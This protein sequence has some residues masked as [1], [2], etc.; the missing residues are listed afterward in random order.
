[1]ARYFYTFSEQGIG[2]T[3]AGWSPI[4]DTSNVSWTNQTDGTN[5]FLRNANSSTNDK[6]LANTEV[7]QV[8]D[9]EVTMK[10]RTSQFGNYEN[11]LFVR[12]SPTNGTKQGYYLALNVPANQ[13]K[14]LNHEQ[15][16]NNGYLPWYA[17]DVGWT[18]NTWYWV[19]Y[20]VVGNNHK[21]KFWQ[22]GTAEPAGWTSDRTDSTGTQYN[23]AGYVALAVY[24]PNGSRDWD[25]VGIA[26]GG[27][28]APTNPIHYAASSFSGDSDIS[29]SATSVTPPKYFGA[30]SMSGDSDMTV[31]G[32]TSIYLDKIT[33]TVYNSTF[34]VG[35]DFTKSAAFSR[36]GQTFTAVAGQTALS[37]IK[38][39]LMSTTSTLGV[40]TVRMYNTPAEAN[41]DATPLGSS[42]TVSPT[43]DSVKDYTL[44]FPN[45][46]TLTPGNSYFFTVR[47][48]GTSVYVGYQTTDVYAGGTR[49][50]VSYGGAGGSNLLAADTGDLAFTAM[51][52]VA[53]SLGAASMSGD[54]DATANGYRVHFATSSFSGDS[55]TTVSVQRQA[56]GSSSF[57]GDSD[58][59]ATG[60]AGYFAVVNQDGDSTMTVNGA[61]AHYGEVIIDGDSEIPDVASSRNAV[62]S[63]SMSGDSEFTLNSGGIDVT[64]LA[65]TKSYI[66]KIYDENW[67][68][69]GIW[70][71]VISDFGY[72]QEINSAG[73]A[74]TVTL[75]RNSDSLIAQ[76]DAIA[77][78]DDEAILT[79]G[80]DE[81]AAEMTTLNAVGPGT[82][83]DLNKNVKIYEF[84]TDPDQPVDGDLVF[85]GYISKY[86]SKYGTAENTDV[87]IFSYGADLDNWV[88]TD[89]TNTRVSY[90]S[91]DPA[92]ILKDT[93]DRF[94]AE[95]GLI[96][97]DVGVPGDTEVTT[98]L[99]TNPS[100]ETNANGW[101][102]THGVGGRQSGSGGMFGTYYF[103]IQNM[104]GGNVSHSTGN[105]EAGNVYRLS[106]YLRRAASGTVNIWGA[107]N[108]TSVFDYYVNPPGTWTRYDIQFTATANSPLFLNIG[109]S[110]SDNVVYIDGVMLTKGPDLLDYFDGTTVSADPDISYGWTGTAHNSTSTKTKVINNEGAT[111]ENTQWYHPGW[112]TTYAFNVNTELEVVKK[113]LELSP[114][115]WFF[116]VD[117]ATN[118]L[119][120]HPRPEK[121]KHYFYLGKH[122]FSLDLEKNME[123]I[124]NDVI[125]TGGKPV[126]I[127]KD[128]FFDV[129]G[130]LLQNHEGELDATWVKHPNSGTGS[131]VITNNRVRS[132]TGEVVYLVSGATTSNDYV[133]T[134]DMRVLSNVGNIGLVGRADPTTNTYYMAR[135]NVSGNAELYKRVAGT[136]TLLKS[137][138]FTVNPG[139]TYKV[140]LKM[141]GIQISLRVDDDTIVDVEDSSI[142]FGSRSGLYS[143]T[144]GTATT[145]YHFNNFTVK[146]FGDSG[147]P[148]FK[149]KTNNDS[150][151]AYRRGLSRIQDNRVTVDQSAE[152]LM[153]NELNRNSEPRYRS[154]ITIS[155]STY[156][157]RSIRLGDLIGFRNFDNFVDA[158]VMQVVRI[159]YNGDSVTLQLDTLLPSV[160]KRLE[161]I[162]RNLAQ[163]DVED[164]PDAPEI[165]T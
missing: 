148:V 97:Y 125:L 61:K 22:D 54:S 159:D 38:L 154:K 14:I 80:G 86:T 57:S 9:V 151:V 116:Y 10:F 5:T 81:L 27:D 122:I 164:N 157:I 115:D 139:N 8:A 132:D 26:T 82:T 145:G 62:S 73:S 79:D 112:I 85:T 95:G 39:R 102:L 56:F 28:T 111:I 114:T 34:A 162:K 51:S 64:H 98:N 45:T 70:K 123:G 143:G 135:I 18:V 121:P 155:G 90:I 15:W 120:F 153:D 149:R 49:W 156:D 130:E 113:L 84:S 163:S 119:H 160:P 133:I 126:N 13:A 105:L 147:T 77:T 137:T 7:G 66:Y 124:V 16:Y 43:N 91:E 87:S 152:L 129:T 93:L 107:H 138:P 42:L 48:Q 76:Y 40:V 158:V 88:L 78:D 17:M 104:M 46:I 146:H 108:S 31:S 29:V 6:L 128:N 21:V 37:A 44:A 101:T 32:N 118:L 89:G 72:S 161:D 165:S 52:L 58:F 35:E 23:S 55:D 100:F 131:M 12:A 24:S 136:W 94:Q 19:R 50:S 30:S 41:A 75:A 103:S 106:F 92:V 71:D 25:F 20:R 2:S 144:S 65:I 67:N 140:E 53:G 63:A 47:S 134:A 3:P 127:V 1:M 96:S 11:T 117:L 99:I 4:W 69:L 60:Y 36:L 59:T 68:Y 74:I 141:E 83:V 109:I 142:M 33:Q 150:I 110:G